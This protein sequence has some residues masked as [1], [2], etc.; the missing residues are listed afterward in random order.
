MYFT[1]KLLKTQS[2]KGKI[3]DKQTKLVGQAA[4]D[5]RQ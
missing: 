2:N 3:K 5:K 1:N 4:K